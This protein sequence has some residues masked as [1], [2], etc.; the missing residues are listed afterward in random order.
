MYSKIFKMYKDYLKSAMIHSKSIVIVSKYICS[1]LAYIFNIN[2][3]TQLS[4]ILW[5]DNYLPCILISAML[6]FWSQ[7]K[8]LKAFN[9]AVTFKSNT[10]PS[11]VL[12]PEKQ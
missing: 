6:L 8:M 12:G 1:K 10:S 5:K 11:E 3:S 7:T 4:K 9:S 2:K